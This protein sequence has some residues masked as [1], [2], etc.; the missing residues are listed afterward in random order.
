MKACEVRVGDTLT[1]DDPRTSE[2]REARVLEVRSAAPGWCTFR[3][4][5]SDLFY[6]FPEHMRVEGVRGAT[7]STLG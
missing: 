2:T 4:A 7:P 6:S 1:V 3:V 5:G